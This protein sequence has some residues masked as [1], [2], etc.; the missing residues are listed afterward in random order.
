MT[1]LRDA[2]RNDELVAE[3]LLGEEG[4]RATHAKETLD[5]V[6]TGAISVPVEGPPGPPPPETP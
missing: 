5:E 1:S 6:V 2:P 4:A 3:L